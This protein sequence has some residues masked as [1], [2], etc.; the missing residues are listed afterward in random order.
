[1][2]WKY[3]VSGDDEDDSDD[4]ENAMLLLKRLVTKNGKTHASDEL[5]L[6]EIAH[7]PSSDDFISLTF[8]F[9]PDNEPFWQTDG[10]GKVMSG[11]NY[12]LDPQVSL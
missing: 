10:E 7:G 6:A 2:T 8:D 12:K 11:L 3:T 9:K 4:D 1:M 5:T